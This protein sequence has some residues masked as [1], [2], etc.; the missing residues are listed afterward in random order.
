MPAK[1]QTISVPVLKMEQATFS[2]IGNSGLYCHRMGAKAKQ[3]LLLGGRKKTAAE[4]LSLKH[5]PEQEFVDSMHVKSGLFDGTQVVFPATAVKS[6]MATAA[7][8][9]DGIKGTDVKRL[10]YIPDEWIP[11]YGIPKLRMDITR[12]ADIGKTPDVRTR[13]FFP[14]WAT[15][16]T[17]RWA[18]PALSKKSIYALLVNAGIMCGI[19]DFRQEKG[20]GG[21]GTWDVVDSIPKSHLDEAG[22]TEAIKE[23]EAYDEDTQWLMDEFHNALAEGRE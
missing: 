14:S 2:L 1:N 17:V 6:A 7:L 19:G 8:V 5:N 23:P 18:K 4:R 13:A 21:F 9:V 3:Q 11:I 12:S 15:Q 16:I 22:Q 20:K 10:V